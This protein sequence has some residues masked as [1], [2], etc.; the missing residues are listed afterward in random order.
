M[1]GLLTIL[2]WVLLGIAAA[3]V[4][5]LFVPADYT[6]SAGTRAGIRV[7]VRWLFGWVRIA[8]D[9]RPGTAARPEPQAVVERARGRRRSLR[10]A[11]VTR[12]LLAIEGLVPRLLRV[13]A[14]LAGSLGWRR[15]RIAVR[16]GLG[17]PADTGE[18]CGLVT[19]VL[20]LLPQRPRLRLEFEPDF[21]AASFEAEAEGSGRFVPARAVAALGRFAVSRPGRRFIGVMLWHRGR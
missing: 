14:E 12:R 15:G 20:V 3:L 5:L 8:H 21:A 1:V 7:R 6:L 4:M 10:A 16:A 9:S 13:I 19:P 17:D 18:L 11:R 2:A